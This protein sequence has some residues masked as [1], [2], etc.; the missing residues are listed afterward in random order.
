MRAL[1]TNDDGVDSPG[2]RALAGAAVEAGLD[3][4]VAAPSWDSTGASASR[5]AVGTDGRLLLEPRH[6]K[7]LPD[8]PVFSVEAAPA[9]IV[10]AGLRGAFGAVPDIVL[11][12][13]NVGANTGGSVLHSGTVG[14]VLT[15]FTQG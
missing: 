3:V 11:S 2:I 10:R 4:V 14:A 9:Y 15:A 8:I 6:F 7:E 5:T 1:V 13:I 12:G